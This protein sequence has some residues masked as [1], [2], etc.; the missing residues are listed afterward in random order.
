MNSLKS[1]ALGVLLLSS[2]AGYLPLR[3]LSPHLAMRRAG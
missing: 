1:M 2:L 3:W